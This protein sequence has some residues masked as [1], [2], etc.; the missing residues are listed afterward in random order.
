[1]QTSHIDI[2][3]TL[4]DIL[5]VDRNKSLEQGL[6]LWDSGLRDRKTFFLG[7]WYFGADG[8]HE[9]GEFQMYSEVLAAA[10]ASNKLQF[11]ASNLLE[12]EDDV[13]KVR[14]KTRKLYAL[15]EEWLQQKFCH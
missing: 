7:N 10:F 12:D 5:G 9:N 6:A 15:Q 2:S 1:M 14:D 3:P 13:L 8:F 11:N 4:F